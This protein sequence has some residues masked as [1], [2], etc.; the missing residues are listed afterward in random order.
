MVDQG[1]AAAARKAGPCPR[2]AHLGRGGEKRQVAGR[3]VEYGNAVEE[4][5]SSML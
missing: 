5:N 2:S 3:I 4:A 1:H